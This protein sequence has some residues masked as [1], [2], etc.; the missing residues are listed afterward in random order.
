[1]ESSK[2]K[3]ILFLVL[4]V[5]SVLIIHILPLFAR[6]TP[7]GQV[8]ISTPTYVPPSSFKPLL[9]RY[10]YSVSWNGIP[11]GSIELE[12]NRKD[13]DY[14]IHAKARTAKG[15]DLVYKLRYESQTVLAADTLKPK[16]SLAVVQTN[17]KEKTTELEFLPDGKISS[18]RKNHQGR[19][20]TLKFNSDN[21]TLDPFS[22]AF[23]ALSQEWKVGENRR[24]DLFSGKS[25]H[26]IELSAVEKTELKVNGAK[27]PAIVIIPTL[28]KKLNVTKE[29]KKK[30][31]RQAKIYISADQ[32]REI[33]K[34]SSDLLF[35]SVNTEMVGFTPTTDK[36]APIAIKK[37]NSATIGI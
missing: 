7:P 11:A 12:L 6:T 36:P 14:E 34:I 5:A 23:L 25:R 32:R 16:H 30:K 20:K 10:S 21:F 4:F 27:R 33:L 18:K 29:T 24:F 8:C 15:I 37:N 2:P 13:D 26:L 1:M 22:A 35:G 31:L 9:G 3:T 17:S 19:V 28:I